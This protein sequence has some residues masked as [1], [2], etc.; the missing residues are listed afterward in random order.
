MPIF[1][2]MGANVLRQDDLYS[3]QI[4]T[5]T[6]D[7]VIPPL[8]K[9]GKVRGHLSDCLY[10]FRHG[11]VTNIH[12]LLVWL[13]HSIKSFSFKCVQTTQFQGHTHNCGKCGHRNHPHIRGCSSPHSWSQ[14]N[15]PVYSSLGNYRVM[16]LPPC[17]PGVVDGEA[18]AAAK[19]CKRWQEQG[20]KLYMDISHY[21]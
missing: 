2:F 18:S 16:W 1:T 19:W 17:G 20:M 13:S 4:I 5:K 15:P 14:E 10:L 11:L 3:F 7:T 12:F 9:V 8:I 6:I 21:A